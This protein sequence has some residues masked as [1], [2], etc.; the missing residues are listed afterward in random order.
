MRKPASRRAL[1]E[2]DRRRPLRAEP[3]QGRGIEEEGGKKENRLIHPE[4]GVREGAE[5]SLE[6]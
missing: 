5:T 3:E 6:K 4:R 2:G 1:A